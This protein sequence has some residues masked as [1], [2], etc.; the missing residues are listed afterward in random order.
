[1]MRRLCSSS[2]F[3]R[4]AMYNWR[5]RA[6]MNAL[7]RAGRATGPLQL[8]DL[9]SLG[10]LDQYHYLGT[11]ACDHVIEMLGIQPG[12]SVLDVGAGIGGPARYL[13]AN[14]GCHVVG[15]ELQAE[16]SEAA[17]ELTARVQGLADRVAF[18]TG[19]FSSDACA[20]P[21]ARADAAP[22]RAPRR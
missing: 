16:L 5:V 7:E 13:S 18:V 8:D 1:M 14:T 21:Q 11:E 3:T 17:A 12:S 6:I 2:A 9:T 22:P 10:H 4:G 15:V 20:M 19:D